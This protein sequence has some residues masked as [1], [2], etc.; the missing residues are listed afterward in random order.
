MFASTTSCTECDRSALAGPSCEGTTEATMTA[1]TKIRT[2]EVAFRKARMLIGGKWVGSAPGEVLE[3]EDP[4]H[5]R[6]IAE[7]PRGGAVDV[8]RAVQAAA[9]AFPAW[10]RTIPR[11]RG[12]LLARIADALEARVEELARTIALETGN[13]LR[14]QARPEAKTTVD[15]IRYFGGLGS[16]LKGET[17]PL[18]EHV[19]SY[20]R[21]EP[22]GV[23]RHHPVERASP[24]GCSEDRPRALCRQHARLE[25]RRGCI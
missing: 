24:T 4:A 19:L 10:S 14:T 13:A 22:L 23:R 1:V 18:G 12:R 2:D 6:P 16:E 5:R 3:V 9:D 8:A 7:V 11:E 25:G 17:I 21:R 15:I 20:T